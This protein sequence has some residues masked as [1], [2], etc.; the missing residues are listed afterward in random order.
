MSSILTW[1]SSAICHLV[2]LQ[3]SMLS[4]YL[5]CVS[6]FFQWIRI[7]N[8]EFVLNFALQMGFRVRNRWKCTILND[9]SGMERFAARLVPKDL[10]HHLTRLSLWTNFWPK[11]QRISSNNH[12]IHLIWLRPTLFFFQK[13][14]YYFEEPVFSP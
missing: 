6:R 12:H 5:K 10:M 11:T 3:C 9:C 4:V 2:C 1:S 14:N 13:L 8:K 7:T